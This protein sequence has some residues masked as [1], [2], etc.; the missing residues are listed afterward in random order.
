MGCCH[1]QRPRPLQRHRLLCCLLAAASTAGSSMLLPVAPTH[2]QQVPASCLSPGQP[3]IRIPELVSQ[4]GKLTGTLLLRS[5]QQRINTANGC[6]TQYVRY[7]S[8]KDTSGA[9]APLPAVMPGSPAAP[10][11]QTDPLP[12]PVPAP[13]LRARVGDIVQLAFINQVNPG[14]F[15]GS[16][17]RGDIGACDESSSGYPGTFEA[18]P[19]CFHGSSTANI[20]FHGTHTNPGS[21][22][23]NI[24]VQVRPAP[25]PYDAPTITPESVRDVFKTFFDNCEAKLRGDVLSEFPFTWDDL[26][27]TW[28]QEQQ[29][30]LDA[31]DKG[32]PPYRPPAKPLAQQLSP[33]N[34]E[35][36]KK[37][38]W[39]QFY[40]GAY[41]F[42]FQLPAYTAGVW[43]PPQPAA[44]PGAP[45][46]LTPPV[47]QMGQSPGTHW[48]HAHKHGSTALNVLNGM[49][50]AFIIEGQYDDDLNRFYG[51]R[52]VPDWTRRQPVLVIGQLDVSVQL[53]GGAIF[54]GG[55]PFSVN[56][57]SEPT[58]TMRP[59]EVQLWRI[60]NASSRSGAFFV[61]PP[62]GFQWKQIAHD[63]VQFADNNYQSP[64]FSNH[65]FLMA[66]GNRVD[67]L[68]KAPTNPTTPGQPVPFQVIPGVAAG[69]FTGSGSTA[70]LVAVEVAGDPVTGRQ[71]QFINKAPSFPP[72][73]AD[74]APAEV[75]GTKRIRFK[76]LGRSVPMQHT[77]DDRQFDDTVGQ[78]V[79][80][81][82]VEE[83]KIENAT[84]AV[85][86]DHPFHI[87]INP[88]QLV[89]VFDPNKMVPNS[90][91]QMVNKYVFTTTDAPPP[92]P[93]TQC[94]VNV[95]KPATWVDCHNVERANE[96]WRD[97]FSIPMGVNQKRSDGA[98]VTIPGY[99]RMRSRFVDFPGLFVFHCHILAHEDR[100]MMMIIDVRP[101]RSPVTHH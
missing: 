27:P 18:F 43:P 59:G 32:L 34:E 3:L 7:F 42:C 85:P 65:S 64:R 95:D 77:I 39:P 38:Q 8:G 52:E 94:N 33:A 53:V 47:L 16:F 63:G 28:I 98:S 2:A 92:D 72:F 61:G 101:Q 96:I 1:A 74:I 90:Q 26:P 87:H 19:D 46:R 97:V 44:S 48:Y 12:D 69:D 20:H 57:R 30:L 89:E 55:A 91:G 67:L 80:L 45:A 82:K 36:S 88:F 84:T 66:S 68:V 49:T 58:L 79:M 23:D 5:R 62:P 50:G 29:R 78:T 93:K 54:P 10:P 41:P 60:V 75:T 71:S 100:G 70:T 25:P 51:T 40:V 9:D 86:I 21:T 15:P 83:W 22:G 24:F 31:Y 81:N 13:T 6:L 99:F 4:S 35:S 11:L 56:G 73:L 14:N 17:D 76:S 37:G